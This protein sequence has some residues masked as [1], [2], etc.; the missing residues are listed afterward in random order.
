M[1]TSH[2]VPPGLVQ[3][4]QSALAKLRQ[5]QDKGAD[6]DRTLQDLRIQLEE[7][8]IKEAEISLKNLGDVRF[9]GLNYEVISEYETLCQLRKTLTAS[10]RNDAMRV[11]EDLRGRH[12]KAAPQSELGMLLEKETKRALVEK[13][14][15]MVG[16]ILII[17]LA[18]GFAK[19]GYD[20]HLKEQCVAAEA[21]AKAEAEQ[22]ERERLAAEAKAKAEAERRELPQK[23]QATK[24]GSQVNVL[25]TDAVTQSFALVPAGSFTMGSPANEDGHSSDE[26]PVEVGLS[27]PFWL[28]KT[29]VTQAQWE[30]VMGSNPSSF[31]GTNL[32]VENVSWKDAQAF[33]AKL[34][35]KR[36]LPSGWEFALPTEAQWEYACRAGEKGPYS[37]GSLDEVGW[38]DGNSGSKTH[39]AGLKKANAWGLYDMHGNVWEW[40]ADW[41]DGTLKGGTD[42]T[43]P[44]SGDLRVIRGGSWSN[45]ASGCRAARRSRSYPGVRVNSLGFRPA[46]V[47]SR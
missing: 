24:V 39:E 12:P 27:H 7:G 13:R 17:C 32:P 4:V 2:E 43:G 29:E 25:I 15:D 6:H 41:Y 31:K 10:D 22:K 37:G 30:A 18:A 28:A 36:I 8:H 23:I 21:K 33:I 1:L 14:R 3:E 20:N 16:L 38:Y 35:E 40:C 47:R 11:V 44:S 5:W 19:L 46:L 34:N 45:F 9:S 42:P 26:N